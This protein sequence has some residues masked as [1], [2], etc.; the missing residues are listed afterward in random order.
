MTG[1]ADSSNSGNKNE[2]GRTT[3]GPMLFFMDHR[4]VMDKIRAR[5]TTIILFFTSL[6][7]CERRVCAWFASKYCGLIPTQTIG[8]ALVA[9]AT[10][11]TDQ[12]TLS[13]D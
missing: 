7:N 4:R 9:G 6:S 11:L 5:N 10:T 2:D 1:T 12:R 3:N 13:V 8:A